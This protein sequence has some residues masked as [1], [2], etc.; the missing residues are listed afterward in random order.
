[1]SG[2][3]P[4]PT[5]T[6]EGEWYFDTKAEL[7]KAFDALGPGEEFIYFKGESLARAV[8]QASK[9]GDKMV[10]GMARHA[11]ALGTLKRYVLYHIA[12]DSD[13]IGGA[14]GLGKGHL[15]QRG[16]KDRF[17]NRTGV[18]EYVL[19]KAGKKHDTPR[20]PKEPSSGTLRCPLGVLA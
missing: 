15:V 6:P 1:M 11:R 5:R 9:A 7:Q 16:L 18:F 20:T 10:P 12:V 17:G 19:V 2:V 13:A 8:L 3:R 14:H 4:S